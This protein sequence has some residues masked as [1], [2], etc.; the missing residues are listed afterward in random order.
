VLYVSENICSQKFYSVNHAL[1]LFRYANARS[2]PPLDDKQNA[3]IISNSNTGGLVNVTFRRARNTQDTNDFTFTENAAFYIL[4][5]KGGSYSTITNE[6]GIHS[7][8]CISSSTF[9]MN[10]CGKYHI[11][12]IIL[13]YLCYIITVIMEYYFIQDQDH[14][15]LDS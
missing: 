2:K 9:K 6:P 1:I 15:R 14:S 8:R 10:T 3:E 5:G 4:V 7:E 11:T 13:I 12:S